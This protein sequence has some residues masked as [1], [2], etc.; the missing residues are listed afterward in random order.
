M[1]LQRKTLFSPS[2]VEL[3]SAFD[4]RSGFFGEIQD[5]AGTVADQARAA[6]VANLA[7]DAQMETQRLTVEHSDPE[8]FSSAHAA[9]TDG[10]V[11][12]VP[13][14]LRDRARDEYRRLGDEALFKLEEAQRE[15]VHQQTQVDF[16]NGADVVAQSGVQAS[17]EGDE[18]NYERSAQQ[19]QDLLKI[20]VN[21]GLITPEEADT[22]ADEFAE[23]TTQ[24]MVAGHYSRAAD[25]PAVILRVLEAAGSEDEREKYRSLF[26]RLNSQARAADDLS[27]RAEED[28]RKERHRQGEQDA[29]SLWLDGSLTPEGLQKMVDADQIPASVARALSRE[30]PSDRADGLA[31][32][33]QAVVQNPLGYTLQ[34]ILDLDLPAADIRRL[35]TVRDAAEADAE[36]WRGS[37]DGR[38]AVRRI[39]AA[40]GLEGT[41]MDQLLNGP[42][43]AQKQQANRALTVFY[44]MVD[45]LP[46]EARAEQLMGIADDIVQ[47]MEAEEAREKLPA[48]RKAVER[49]REQVAQY[50]ENTEPHS[51]ATDRLQ[52][53]ISEVQ[54]LEKRVQD[55]PTNG[56]LRGGRS[57]TPSSIWA[58]EDSE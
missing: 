10:V 54:Q 17:F 37:Q 48:A 14:H 52:E 32:D 11:S 21:T 58:G 44:Q 36:N 16:L 51:L 57:S 45:G 30:R 22:R 40:A 29:T 53:L 1:P 55:D 39:N 34:D 47:G 13:W 24:E 9:M 23:K 7:F 20:G 18:E 42:T 41:L 8:A 33:Y 15:R 38:E 56:R 19:Y 12:Q 50:S 35:I 26:A 46:L 31:L 25:K 43:D 2:Q 4:A 6:Y 3:A 49:A 28:A 5:I 27:N